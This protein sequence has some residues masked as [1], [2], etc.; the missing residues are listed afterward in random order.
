M[1]SLTLYICVRIDGV[2]SPE[3]GKSFQNEL[4]C[5]SY[6]AQMNR[7][8]A[9][10]RLVSTQGVPAVLYN[11]NLLGSISRVLGIT[12]ATIDAEV[13]VETNYSYITTSITPPS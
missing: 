3:C 4:D 10:R 1:S 7:L 9:V 8:E 12:D 11:S 13:L 2:L 5:Q 6:V